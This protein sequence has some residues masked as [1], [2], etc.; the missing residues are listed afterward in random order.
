MLR[1]FG[2]VCTC[3]N[4]KITSSAVTGTPSLNDGWNIKGDYF[5]MRSLTATVPMD[6]AFPERFQSAVLTLSLN[7]FYTWSAESFWGTVTS[8][9]TS[10]SRYSSMSR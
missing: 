6:F 10:R 4:V 8:T 1:E 9:V 7:N 3:S 5:K 2:L